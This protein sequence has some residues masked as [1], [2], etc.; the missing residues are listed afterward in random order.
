MK[1]T[2][3]E[4]FDFGLWDDYCRLTGCSVWAANEGRISSDDHVDMPE[5]LVG[6]ILGR[7]SNPSQ[8]FK[9]VEL[10]G[11]LVEPGH[12]PVKKQ[13]GFKTGEHYDGTRWY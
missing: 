10:L 9:S 1:V 12:A 11:D 13:E 3:R 7:E 8:V 5:E 4:L 6:R 2:V